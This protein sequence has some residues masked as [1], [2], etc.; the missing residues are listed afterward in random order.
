MLF[1][2]CLPSHIHTH[3]QAHTH[4]YYCYLLYLLLWSGLNYMIYFL[5]IYMAFYIFLSSINLTTV[6]RVY[7]LTRLH[8][9][10]RSHV[11]NV[12]TLNEILFTFQHRI[13]LC[14]DYRQTRFPRMRDL[15]ARIFYLTLKDSPRQ[16]FKFFQINF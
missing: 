4:D 1:Y 12:G 11:A 10:T 3:T 9:Y 14:S 6:Q 5:E 15:K 2:M 13:F 16:E 7:L 8:S